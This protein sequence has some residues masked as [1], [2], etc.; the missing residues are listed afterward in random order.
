MTQRTSPRLYRLFAAAVALLAPAIGAGPVAH[1]QP[2]GPEPPPEIAGIVHVCSS[3]HGPQGHPVSPNFPYLAAQQKDYLETQLKGMRDH[4]RDDPHVRTYMAGMA[5]RLTDPQIAALSAYYAAQP[6]VPG[7]PNAEA[8]VAVGR[9]I[10]TQGIPAASIPPCAAC[11]GDK[12]EGNG[13]I[14]RL[15]GQSAEYVERELNDFKTLGRTNEIMH[16]NTLK[17]TPEQ[18]HEVALYLGTL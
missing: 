11:H 4:T 9:Q 1:A 10:Y 7:Q 18:M 14:P 15:A 8:G 2:A 3:C 17:M 6:P 16:Q 5:A 13:A 12:G